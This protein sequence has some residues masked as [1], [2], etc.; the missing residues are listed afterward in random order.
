MHESEKPSKWAVLIPPKPVAF[1]LGAYLVGLILFALARLTFLLHF[2][3]QLDQISI[4]RT[5]VAFWI[6]IRFDTIILAA[7]LAPLVLGLPVFIR[8]PRL[9]PAVMYLVAVCSFLFLLLLGDIRFYEEFGTH[10]NFH[11]LDYLTEGRTAW[12]LVLGDMMFW[13]LVAIWVG[14]VS[15]LIAGLAMVRKTIRRLPARRNWSVTI[16]Y[17][18][19][20]LMLTALGIRGRV[21]IAPIDWGVAYFSKNHFLN[22]LA[23]NGIYTL[24]R[25]FTEQDSRLSLLKPPQR[26][27]FTDFATALDTT[28]AML[29]LPHEIWLEPKRS[30]KRLAR[31][32]DANFKFKPNIVLV[33]ME[34]FSGRHTGCLGSGLDLTPHFDSL[35]RHGILFTN[36]YSTGTRTSYGIAG[37]IGSFPS[38]PG[39]SI[40]KRYDAEHPFITLSELL[41]G[42][43]YSNTFMYGGDLVF[44][45]M[46]GFL[47]TKGYNR[48]AGEEE[49]DSDSSF[50][51]WGLP[52]HILFGEAIELTR[53]LPRPFQLTILTL[54]NHSPFELP[55]SSVRRYLGDDRQS[56]VFNAQIY[57]DWAL[58]QFMAAASQTP[59][60]DST[61]F[62]FTADHALW[63]VARYALDPVNL[64]IPLLIYA[65]GLLGDS[66]RVIE[67]LSG[68]CDLLPTL[69]GL[70]G[71][72]YIHESWGRDLLKLPP[73]DPGFAMFNS[74]HYLGYLLPDLFLVERIGREPW[75]LDINR[76]GEDEAHMADSFPERLRQIRTR[77]HHYYQ[78]AEQ[79]T[80]PPERR[81][82]H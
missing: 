60:Y 19:V 59:V 45:N 55:D 54:S 23:L 28:R 34:S 8:R 47:K 35:A 65:P 17:L 20:L 44:D 48:I 66:G 5:L 41:A 80:I 43:S 77:L 53:Q 79:L 76:L 64:H 13:T 62:V 68:H 4:F 27:E 61:I 3:D 57:A 52:D 49:F 74:A 26:W 67:T 37:T 7:V 38:L 2:P 22:Q 78:T 81:S 50:S 36:F 11:V 25:T 21:D 24:G 58:G 39:R 63:D 82:D 70:L 18:V 31:Q 6:G 29:G 75:L 40:L 16:G 46:A 30:L 12:N 73:D 32:P 71:G 69:M 9:T 51:K 72:E 56:R 14:L 1:I 42:R 15:L 10:L 33:L